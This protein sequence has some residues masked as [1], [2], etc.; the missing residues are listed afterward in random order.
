MCMATRL[1]SRDFYSFIVKR[2]EQGCWVWSGTMHRSGYGTWGRELA[3]RHSWEL[4]NGPIPEGAWILHHCDNKPCVNPLHLYA[5]TRAENVQDAVD[6]GR[7]KPTR[8]ARCQQGHLKEGDNLIVVQSRGRNSYRCRRC[9]N[10]RK[11][12]S[13][14]QMRRAAGPLLRP[15]VDGA[16][17][18]R[19]CDLR[20]SGLA[21]RAIAKETGRALMTVQ[22]TL[23]AAGL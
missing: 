8:K 6:R 14:R 3:H 21:H 9:D 2:H 1:A 13:A 7:I 11:A 10:E 16:E 4:A 23:K 18:K 19:I 15:R 5:G 12:A 20:R 22:R 17:A